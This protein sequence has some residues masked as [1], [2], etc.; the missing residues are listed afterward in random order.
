M[1]PDDDICF[2]EKSHL[3]NKVV[4]LVERN[5]VNLLM[6]VKQV[7][8]EDNEV[9]FLLDGNVVNDVNECI[10][11]GDILG[12]KMLI[13]NDQ[14]SCCYHHLEEKKRSEEKKQIY[15]FVL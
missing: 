4:G 9:R 13:P 5:S 15:F 6:G 12:S 11:L 14:D 2:R 3:V 8:E 1:I 7:T 10:N